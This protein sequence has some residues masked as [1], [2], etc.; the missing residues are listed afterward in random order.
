M[1]QEVLQMF[2]MDLG[3]TLGAKSQEEAIQKGAKFMQS[4]DEEQIKQ[5]LKLHTRY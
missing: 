4:K 3:I 2:A 1:D 5:L